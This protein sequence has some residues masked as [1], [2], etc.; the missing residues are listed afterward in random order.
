MDELKIKVVEF[1]DKHNILE[2]KID[3]I[4]SKINEQDLEYN[5]RDN[6]RI[7]CSCDYYAPYI[8]NGSCRFCYGINK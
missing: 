5:I 7:I 8:P 1:I 3:W 6:K 2:Q 4:L